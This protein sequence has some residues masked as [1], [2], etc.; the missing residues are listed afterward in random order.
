MIITRSRWKSKRAV[1]AVVV[2]F[3]ILIAAS[4]YVGWD[5]GFREHPQPAWVSA[6]PDMR[7]KYGS[8]GAE[9]DAG[10]PYWIF[11]VLPRVFPEKLPGPGG[12]A[13]L[14]VPWEQ[15]QE[16]PVGF[17]KKTIGFPRV[18]N[19]C[20]VCHTATYRTKANENPTFVTAA[21]GHTTDV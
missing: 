11:Y 17:T 4:A 5:R 8:I 9:Q 18:A 14:G 13:A 15:G 19:N 6:T 20:A 1:I 10:I 2:L 16:L 7:F 21:P 3:I 12:Y